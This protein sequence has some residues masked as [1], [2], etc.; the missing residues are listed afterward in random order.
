MFCIISTTETFCNVLKSYV[1]GTFGNFFANI[2]WL[3]H[4]VFFLPNFCCKHLLL[5]FHKFY[6]K[7]Q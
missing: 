3:E 5:F 4:L 7:M 6:G 2:L 1:V